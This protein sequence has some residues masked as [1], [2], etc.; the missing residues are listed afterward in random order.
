MVLE[1]PHVLEISDLDARLEAAATSLKG[2]T[3]LL[4]DDTAM[5]NMGMDSKPSL[6]D[7]L[8]MVHE[9]HRFGGD[10]EK[11]MDLMKNVADIQKLHEDLGH[12]TRMQVTLTLTLTR[13]RTLSLTL[14]L[15]LT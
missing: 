15:T 2:F 12:P 4:H 1:V 5:L 6:E 13:T 11:A 10:V 9:L 7:K 3:T 8:Y 14:S